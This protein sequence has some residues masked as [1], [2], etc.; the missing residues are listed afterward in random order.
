VLLATVI[1]RLLGYRD[2]PVTSFGNL[3]LDDTNEGVG[4]QTTT[5]LILAVRSKKVRSSACRTNHDK[6]TASELFG[7]Y[8][9]SN[10]IWFEILKE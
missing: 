9:P 8:R 4:D 3:K 1:L 5:R 6:D 7:L 2:I 10:P